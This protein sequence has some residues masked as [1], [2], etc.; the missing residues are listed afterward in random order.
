MRMTGSRNHDWLSLVTVSG[1]VVSDPVLAEAF[2]E[3]PEHIPPANHRAF[4]REWERY[5]Q[6]LQEQRADA[7]PR[8]L[9][10]IAEDLLGL[11]AEH[12][13]R[14]PDLPESATCQLVEYKQVLRPSWVLLG[15][16][17]EHSLL[18]SIVP[19]GQ[20]LDRKEDQSGKWRASPAVK[21]E[22][23]LRETRAQ[24]GLLTNGRE[25]R[26]MLV[27]PGLSAS[28]MTFEA[29]T[30]ADE[31]PTLDGFFTLMRRERFFGPEDKRLAKLIADSQEKQLQVT[32]QLGDQVR[33]ALESFVRGLDQADRGTS[34]E[35]LAEMPHDR[36]YEMALI[37][38]M[39]LVFML[40]GEENY[41]L[42]HGEV[43]Y[44]QAYG[45][46]HLY[47]HLADQRRRAPE[48]MHQTF[49][50]WPRLLA[51][52]RLVHDGCSHPD[53]NLIAYGGKLFDPARFSVL[54]DPRVRIPNECI[55]QILRSLCFAKGKLGRETVP[56]RLSYQAL[57]IEQI[58]TVYEGLID[59][60]VQRAPEDDTLLVFKGKGQS[61]RPLSEV[62][63]RLTDSAYLQ[64]QTGFSA[65][66]V[67]K[68]LEQ[69]ELPEDPPEYL[70]PEILS[71]AGFIDAVIPPGHLYVAH[72]S[73]LRKGQGTYYTP[74]WITSFICERTLEPLVFD[75][76]EEARR[77]RSPEEILALKVC[78]PAMGSGAFLVQA[79]R[80][81]ADRLVDSW[82]RL[83][84]EN[85]DRTL[86]MPFGKPVNGGPPDMVIPEDHKEA[87]I[88]ARRFVAEHCLYG[89]DL[90]PLAVELARMS[91]WLITLSKDKPFEFF[92]H[93]LKH[94]NSLIGCWT[95]D[96]QHYPV[97]AWDRKGA[98]GPVKEALKQIKKDAKAQAAK[99]ERDLRTG[100]LSLM[101]LDVD[102]LRAETAAE[103]REIDE[104]STFSPQ[105]RERLYQRNIVQDERYQ[106]LK[107]MFDTWC[108]LWFWPLPHPPAPSPGREGENGGE[109]VLPPLTSGEGDTARQRGG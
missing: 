109:A 22:R 58:G 54:E 99:Q 46:T 64:E 74:K 105:E 79:C 101:S 78:D 41:L 107:R 108:A 88:W 97:A 93:K 7:Q 32:D 15:P 4:I 37:V 27:P 51:T 72:Q 28:H 103:M 87:V 52:F 77:I 67:Q 65:S 21:L 80:Y 81:L 57:D 29:G 91:L 49:D 94:G 36:I 53:L 45:V 83:A 40:Y 34:G 47:S 84:A 62:S 95:S 66:R 75:G 106:A 44:D 26:L 8:W 60:T 70:P 9:R 3:G 90:N 98:E 48:S 1:L 71:H 63:G 82:D 92:D 11:S 17:G 10:F 33:N 6:C 56:Q 76:K 35:L 96:L 85:P 16:D 61:L 18:V 55:Y 89:V 2:P 43:L 102:A 5:Q 38:M 39:R 100:T 50:A 69:Q 31:K 13:L 25:F 12:W 59:Y 19:P 20:S 30:W 23:L 68:L 104:V 86:T 73:G 24:L 42:P 14:H